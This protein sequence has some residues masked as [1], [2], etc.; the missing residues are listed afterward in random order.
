MKYIKK[1]KEHY[2]GD[3][4]SYTN[5]PDIKKIYLNTNKN[6]V[7]FIDVSNNIELKCFFLWLDLNNLLLKIGTYHN[8]KE[9]Y[10]YRVELVGTIIKNELICHVLGNNLMNTIQK[11]MNLIKNKILIQ[12]FSCSYGAFRYKESI[13]VPEIFEIEMTANKYNI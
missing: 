7:I 12:D 11:Y 5:D 3:D 9:K 4:S 13:N 6:D 10:K 1:Y 2:S 8:D